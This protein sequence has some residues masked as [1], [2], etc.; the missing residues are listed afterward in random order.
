MLSLLQSRLGTQCSDIPA[1][2]AFRSPRA[3]SVKG[4]GAAFQHNS[5]VSVLGSR[6]LH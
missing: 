1:E 4:E 6:S 2:S 5:E 3:F